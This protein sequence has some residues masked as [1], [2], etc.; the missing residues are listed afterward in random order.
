MG[1]LIGQTL[2]KAGRIAAAD[3][4]SVKRTKRRVTAG[5]HDFLT[6]PST[7]DEPSSGLEGPFRKNVRAF[8]ARCGRRVP[9][10]AVLARPQ[11]AT[12]RV[13]FRL[14]G[15]SDGGGPPAVEV[16]VVEE[17]VARSKNV[18]CDD[19]RVVGKNP[20]SAGPSPIFIALIYRWL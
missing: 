18:Y 12:W 13:A 9:P 15:E 1:T 16:D 10:H 3:G 5:M 11:L 8:V 2:G 17:D 4:R 20:I 7:G 19:C 6:F 14:G